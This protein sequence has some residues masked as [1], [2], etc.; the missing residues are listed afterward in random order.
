MCFRAD[1]HCHSDYS[2]GS[3]S[4]EDLVDHAAAIGLKGLSITDHDTIGAYE[5]AMCRAEECDVL[6]LPGVEISA[7]YK[8]T[9]VH[10]LGYSFHHK[11]ASVHSLCQKRLEQRYRRNK[12]IVGLLR[13]KGIVFDE[14]DLLFLG[15]EGGNEK[16]FSV[17]RLHIAQVLQRKGFVSNIQEAFDRYIGDNKPCYDPGERCSVEEAIKAI[18]QG[19][20]VAVLAH[21]HLIKRR[22]AVRDLLKMDFD[23]LE[24][25]YARL[26]LSQEKKWLDFAKERG[27][28][29]TGGSDFH[30]TSKPHVEMGCSWVSEEVFMFLYKLYRD[31]VRRNVD[32]V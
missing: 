20:G 15:E 3:M 10:I 23:G 18:R 12:K 26:P 6:L 32:S 13:G 7:S 14:E 8:E 16:L 11:S 5:K 2:D 29:L 30:G 4:P 22:R 28:L 24:G 25:Y 21:P 27:C 31:N 17:G 9:S 1:L 19:G